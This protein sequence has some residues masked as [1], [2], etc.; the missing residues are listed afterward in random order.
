MSAAH[1]DAADPQRILPDV[2]C[3]ENMYVILLKDVPGKEGGSHATGRR[4]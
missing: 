2:I 3:D 1:E 4:I